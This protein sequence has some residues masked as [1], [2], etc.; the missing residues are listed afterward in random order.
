MRS[1]DLHR[2]VNL[3]GEERG[4]TIDTITEVISHMQTDSLMSIYT[5]LYVL[6]SSYVHTPELRDGRASEGLGLQ[7]YFLVALSAEQLQLQ[8]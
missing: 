3:H 1:Q 7:R 8:T 5:V 2:A 4:A 6:A